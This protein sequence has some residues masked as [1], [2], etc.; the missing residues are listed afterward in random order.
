[1]TNWNLAETELVRNWTE[2]RRKIAFDDL[3]QLE[4]RLQSHYERA[5]DMRGTR[6]FCE[7][8]AWDGHRP[9]GGLKAEVS[10]LVGWYRPDKEPVLGSDQAYEV[11]YRHIRLALPE[12]ADCECHKLL[13]VAKKLR[14]RGHGQ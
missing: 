11:A 8:T 9:A 1:M 7:V 4:P 3:A 12:C 10:K 5:R 13:S 6:K 14:Q 2:Q